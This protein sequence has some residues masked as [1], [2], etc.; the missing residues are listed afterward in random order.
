MKKCEKDENRRKICVGNEQK[1]ENTEKKQ[2]KKSFAKGN[3]R[4]KKLVVKGVTLFW[5]LDWSSRNERQ[6][7][8]R[9]TDTAQR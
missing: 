7:F 8:I 3:L 5:E 2:K 4:K 9:I 1:E 6:K